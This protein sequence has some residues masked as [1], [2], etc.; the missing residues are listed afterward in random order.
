MSTSL[1]V[2]A[3]REDITPDIGAIL[4]GYAPGRPAKSIHDHLHVTAFAFEYGGLRS[5]IVTTDLLLISDPLLTEMRRAM[6]DA[7]GIPI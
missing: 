6:S 2:G 5:L 3:G 1:L 4:M 7:A